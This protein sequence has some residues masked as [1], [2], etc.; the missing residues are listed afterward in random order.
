MGE[1]E[2]AHA[3]QLAEALALLDVGWQPD[4]VGDEV[5]RAVMLATALL[6]SAE[7]HLVR[8]ELDGR[9]AGADTA[10]LRS[11]YGPVR[12]EVVA[13]ALP[14]A[15]D[16]ERLVLVLRLGLL[17]A[18]LSRA[19]GPDERA[20][21]SEA[22]AAARDLL[23]AAAATVTHHYAASFAAG[24]GVPTAGESLDLARSMT[25]QAA[26]RLARLAGPAG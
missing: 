4:R 17:V 13:D 15:P 16:A 8:A 20:P 3:E 25:T 9:R 26:V 23:S 11:A 24:S 6:G 1:R 14:G 2:A 18:D 21:D 10:A 22:L 19:A 5:T 7:A 12:A